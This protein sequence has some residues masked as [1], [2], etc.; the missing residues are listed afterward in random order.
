MQSAKRVRPDFDLQADDLIYVARICRLTQGMPLGILLAAAWVDTLSLQEI[1]T[2]IDQSLDFLET[3]LRDVPERQRFARFEVQTP[4]VQLAQILQNRPH[5]IV[6]A[7]AHAA[8][9]QQQIVCGRRPFDRFPDGLRVVR[10]VAEVGH[11]GRYTSQGC[12]QG[13]AVGFVD[14]SGPE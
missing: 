4:E 3:E 10:E 5:V 12:G 1:A 6:I 7:D 2:E 8:T 11:L 14:L 13:L 9:G